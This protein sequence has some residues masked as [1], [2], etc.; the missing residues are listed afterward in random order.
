MIEV[1]V[2]ILLISNVRIVMQRKERVM[3]LYPWP[4]Y[5]DPDILSEALDIA[6]RYLKLTGQAV[7]FTEV[8]HEAAHAMLVAW[9]S[10]VRHKIQ[11]ANCGIAAVEKGASGQDLLQSRAG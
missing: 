1:G 10:G 8:R 5:T 7:R 6:M 9:R 3:L 4:L 2:M 11:L